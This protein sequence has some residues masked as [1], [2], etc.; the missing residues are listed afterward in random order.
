VEDIDILIEDQV[1]WQQRAGRK[2]TAIDQMHNEGFDHD[3]G[4]FGGSYENEKKGHI[5]GV[6][7]DLVPGGISHIQYA[8]DTVIMI[9]G[10]DSR[11]D[12]KKAGPMESDVGRYSGLNEELWKIPFLFCLVFSFSDWPVFRSVRL[13]YG[14]YIIFIIHLGMHNFYYAF[15][16]KHMTNESFHLFILLARSRS[17]W[18]YNPKRIMLCLFIGISYVLHLLFPVFFIIAGIYTLLLCSFRSTHF[19]QDFLILLSS[20]DSTTIDF[21]LYE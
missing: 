3:L 8:D 21:N 4:F 18:V 5:S 17:C 6:L 19:L 16:Y 13:L 7:G 12:G 2:W 14:V 20:E 15:R 11:K 9:D 1:F 10:S